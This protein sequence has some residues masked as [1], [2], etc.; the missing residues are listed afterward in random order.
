MG[1]NAQFTQMDNELARLLP[2]TDSTLIVYE[3]FK[4]IFGDEGNII[5][6]GTEG[7]DLKELENFLDW[8]Q[9]AIDLRS[10]KGVTGVASMA[11][12]ITLDRNDSLQ[13]FE[14][15]KLFE[16]LPTSQAEL[17]QKLEALYDLPFYKG[18][19]YNEENGALIMAV[20]IDKSSLDNLERF[21]IVHRMQDVIDTYTERSGH[22]VH[23]SGFPYIRSV[24][25]EK[26]RDEVRFF[27]FLALGV[28]ALILFF[29]FR[30][31]RAMLFSMLV[32]IIAVVWCFGFAALFDFKISALTGLIPPLIIVIGVPNCI[33]LLNKYHH[34]YVKHGNQVKA[35]S[36]VIHK[37]GNATLMTNATT[38][39]GFATF[40]LTSSRIMVEFGIMASINIM[41]VFF[42]SLLLIPIVYSFSKPPK[43][44]HTAHLEKRWINVVVN[45]MEKI[46][47]HHRKAIFITTSVI[48][49]LAAFGIGRMKK[50]GSLAEDLPQ[51]TKLYKDLVFFEKNFTGVLP[52]EILIDT[53]RKKGVNSMA[54]MKRMDKLHELLSETP[55]VS[56]SI[57]IVD[58]VKFSKQ[59]FYNG[60]PDF[61]SLPTSQEKNLIL[62]YI[63]NSSGDVSDLKLLT[64]TSGSIA[65]VSAS[66]ADIGTG[67][68]RQLQEGLRPKIDSIFSPERYKVYLTGSSVV[69]IKGTYY[70]VENLILSLCIAVLL[71]SIFMALMFKSA[72]MVIVSLI[73]N[74]I[75]LLLT[76]SLMGYFNIPLKPSTI[77]VFSITFGISVDDTIH[78]LAKYR[79]ELAHR[80]WNI[81]E[82][83]IAALRETGVSMTYTSIVLFFGFSIFVLS[84][85]GGTR[86]LGLL[87][88]TTLFV[89]MLANLL[90]LPSLLLALEKKLTTKTFKEPLIDIF[91]DDEDIDLNELI[92]PSNED[93]NKTL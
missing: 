4:E 79:Q 29:F 82:S 65:R 50:T 17:D 39:S 87:V 86:A 81:G 57:S 42:L 92:L 78:F 51:H 46:V 53:Q 47:V 61:Y 90:L 88:S 27:I 45:W 11:D 25:A 85:F 73:P 59:A 36:R 18:I 2:R 16:T 66:I 40:M 9:L 8:N 75:P 13:R 34:E 93:E 30:S 5:V 63:S 48:I 71:I 80:N 84:E 60:N 37:I 14:P 32:V 41:A 19:L 28:T 68:M 52:F 64:D 72:R 35:L 74:L 69:F 21:R 76:G 62:K 38:A 49:L 33:F 20:T 24:S 31:F 91:D 54:T 22:E 89:A 6:I 58:L 12:V 67:E 56:R 1:Y 70:L 43:D 3:K 83:V 7:K 23:V 44:R 10:Q 77:L 26:L 55:Y 15:L